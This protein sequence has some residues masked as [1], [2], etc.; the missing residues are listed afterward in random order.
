[1]DLP[2][3]PFSDQRHAIGNELMRDEIAV[4]QQGKGVRWSSSIHRASIPNELGILMAGGD[5]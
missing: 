2:L 4:A 3:G 5:V 1:M